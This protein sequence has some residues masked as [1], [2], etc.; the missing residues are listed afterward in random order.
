VVRYDLDKEGPEAL[1]V[2]DLDDLSVES[3]TP[4]KR[5]QNGDVKSGV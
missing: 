4:R 1:A 2:L 3:F 5:K